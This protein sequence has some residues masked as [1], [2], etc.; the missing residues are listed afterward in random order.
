M[1]GV[2]T[3]ALPISFNPRGLAVVLRGKKT[4]VLNITDGQSIPENRSLDPR[5]WA[6]GQ[7]T[8]FETTLSLPSDLEA[9]Q[10]DVLLH[11]FDP[12]TSLKNKP[13]FAIRLANQGVWE[14]QTGLNKIRSLEIL[15]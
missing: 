2:Q 15:P 4:Y 3:C 9:G 12:E 10:Y 14:S 7:T 8:Q 11:L 6:A 13:E 5:F 1:T